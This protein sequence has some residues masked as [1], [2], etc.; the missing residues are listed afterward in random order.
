MLAD[1]RHGLR[2]LRRRPGYA[3]AGLLVLGLAV[4]VVSAALTLVDAVLLRPLPL[5]DPSRVVSL[6]RRSRGTISRGFVYPEFVRIERYSGK[7][8]DA[9]AG[10]GDKYLPVATQAGVETSVV[11]FVTKRFFDV[12]GVRPVSGR[13]F[14]HSEHRPG[15]PPVAIVTH[16][17]WQSRLA[18]DQAAV[19]KTINVG[20][21]AAVVAGVLPRAFRGL[22]LTTPVDLYMPLRSVPLVATPG[23]FF[24]ETEVSIDGVSRS[25]ERW[26]GVTARLQ[27][28]V[29][30][31]RTEASLTAI[32]NRTKPPDRRDD[33]VFP[34]SAA[35]AA[36]SSWTRTETV[37]FV[38]MLVVVSGMIFCAGCASVVGMML[39]RNE[40]R[41]REMEARVCLGA[42]R[43]RIFLLVLAEALL[44][45]LFGSLAGLLAAA[46]LVPVAGR[47][48]VLP[49]GI[50]IAQLDAGRRLYAAVLGMAAV[51]APAACGLAPALQAATMKMVSARWRGLVLAG[52]VAVVVVLAIG[53]A[54][55]VRSM[56]ASLAVDVGLDRDRL[57]YASVDLRSSGYDGAAAAGF[58]G[59]VLERVR[60]MPGVES[61]TFGHLPLV[62][63]AASTVYLHADGV[64]R[65]VPRVAIF[66]CG[67][68]YARTVGWRLVAGRN[69]GDR[70]A[71]GAVPVAIVSE[72][73]AR[74]LWGS[75][76]PVGR[77]FHFQPMM[78]VQVVGVVRDGRYAGLSDAGGFSM[79][80]PW[81]QNRDLALHAG[82]I[83]GR[84]AREAG[85]LVSVLQRGIQAH[86]ST[87]P[88]MEA[89]TFRDRIDVLTRPQR[90]GAALLSGLGG[91]AL[92]LAV[93]GVYGS[94]AHAVACRTRDVGIRLALGA[95]TMA[96]IVTTATGTLRYAGIGL[97]TGAGATVLLA[98]LA[99]PYLFEVGPHDSVTY[100]SVV[101]AVATA[102]VIAG[103][104]P[105]FRA[106]RAA[107]VNALVRKATG[108]E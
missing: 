36:L 95:S 23:N 58:Y 66:L 33:A 60:S 91:F 26:I 59:A 51:V 32:L 27:P 65:R 5:D 93:F 73:L 88:V 16:A 10:V 75:E 81:D 38:V 86:D 31:A 68:D 97:L 12:V 49:G 11:S 25:P 41:R 71:E 108:A 24:D 30:A 1:I 17:F 40:Q 70:D 69:F 9:V 100:V 18:G 76:D 54:L 2:S 83:I 46:W 29:R 22:S 62:N 43:G 105:A 4:G 80:M 103:V 87:L 82:T 79:F 99:E 74:R 96:I 98:R 57:F 14:I 35:Y 89:A 50:E 45:T 7:Y 101:T 84:A 67:P 15:A 6:Q 64:T 37:T 104:V 39:V 72:S 63:R 107:S 44:L 102:A 28:G 85:G 77:R 78:E 3:V 34:V 94:T 47:F 20:S 55:F 56:R 90:M 21:R 48:V 19:G 13:G 92:V 52:Q 61:A 42:T 53:A 8:F 106:T